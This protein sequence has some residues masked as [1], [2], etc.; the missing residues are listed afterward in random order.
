MSL[1]LPKGGPFVWHNARPHSKASQQRQD[2]AITIEAGLGTEGQGEVGPTVTHGKP[3]HQ[4]N[5]QAAEPLAQHLFE[6][7]IARKNVILLP[8][9]PPHAHSGH[10]PEHPGCAPLG[11]HAIHPVGRL[12]H[13]LQHQHATGQGWKTRECR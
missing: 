11:E 6:A 5:S 13:I 9:K 4:R 8:T 3:P 10:A 12:P 7:E 1:G 2:A